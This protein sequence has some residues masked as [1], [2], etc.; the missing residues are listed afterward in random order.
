MQCVFLEFFSLFIM[1]IGLLESMKV[2][3]VSGRSGSSF[4]KPLKTCFRWMVAVTANAVALYS[5]LA[6]DNAM[7][8]GTKD[9]PSTKLPCIYTTKAP[10]LRDVSTQSCHD[11]SVNNNIGNSVGLNS[12]HTS[13]ASLYIGGSSSGEK[14]F[15]PKSVQCILM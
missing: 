6:I 9:T 15:R 1:A 4:I 5:D 7:G 3:K 14:N 10:V 8:T 12:G 2:R 13:L 11:E